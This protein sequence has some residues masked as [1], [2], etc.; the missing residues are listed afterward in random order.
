MHISFDI[1]VKTVISLWLI[2]AALYYVPSK[3]EYLKNIAV[4]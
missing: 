4:V 1:I 3:K 2:A